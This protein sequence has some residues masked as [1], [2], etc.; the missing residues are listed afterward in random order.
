MIEQFIDYCQYHQ[1]T[2]A[3]CES[4]TGG[5]LASMITN[6]P[7]VSSVYLGGYVVYSEHA[8][9]KMLSIDDDFFLQYGTVSQK[10]ATMLAKKTSELLHADIAI[11]IV[12]N[13]GPDASSH[14]PVGQVYISVAY[15]HHLLERDFQLTGSRLEVKNQACL[16]AVNALLDI[17]NK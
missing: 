14:Q 11:A 17:V 3:T 5:D 13:A 2:F 4:M 15:K 6:I 12:G 1:L 7:S 9:K 10:T 16:R 8:K